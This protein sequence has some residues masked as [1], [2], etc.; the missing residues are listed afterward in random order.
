MSGQTDLDGL[1]RADIDRV[2]S[3]D[4]AIGKGPAARATQRH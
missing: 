2:E 4:F 1:S 3:R